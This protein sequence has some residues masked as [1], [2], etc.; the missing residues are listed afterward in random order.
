MNGWISIKDELPTTSEEQ[1]ICYCT[2][3]N[4]GELVIALIWDDGDWYETSKD[5]VDW[6]NH[7]THWMPLPK[8][9]GS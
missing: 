6:N 3:E 4:N 8:P 7:V 9:P 5:N 1:Y 2:H